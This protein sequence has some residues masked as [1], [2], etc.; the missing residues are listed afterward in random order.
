MRFCSGTSCRIQL[1]VS[2]IKFGSRL[3]SAAVDLP[4]ARTR[5]VVGCVQEMCVFPIECLIQG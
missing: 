2:G 4:S 3:S 5:E 1:D